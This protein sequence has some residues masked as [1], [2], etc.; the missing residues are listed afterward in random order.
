MTATLRQARRADIPAM[1]CVR[2]AV[3][4]NR[5]ESIVM[6]EPSDRSTT[7][8]SFAGVSAFALTLVSTVIPSA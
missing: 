2:L 5:L 7:S 8:P 3:R 4:E 6:E 1:H